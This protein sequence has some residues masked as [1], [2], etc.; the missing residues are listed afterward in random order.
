MTRLL[1]VDDD[2]AVRVTLAA[3]LELEGFEIVE[4]DS[5]ESALASVAAS[6]ADVV[7]SDVRMGG[8]NGVDLLVA[9]RRAHPD[10]PVVLT[11][12]F[13]SEELLRRAYMNGAFT[14]LPK[15]FQLDRAIKALNRAKRRPR[16]LVVDDVI[17]DAD[18]LAAAVRSTGSN[19][20]AV[21]DATLAL[22]EI[23]T[24]SYDVLVTDLSMPD[25]DGATLAAKAR[26]LDP[27]LAVIAFSAYSVP[28]IVR[29]VADVG[30]NSFIRKPFDP[31]K[32]IE[33]IAV[34]RSESPL[35]QRAV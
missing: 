32:L 10:L 31:A 13:S 30:I 28:E 33:A 4:A 22:D 35:P 25:V 18:S 11:T 16:V 6:K 20:T 15:P 3:N 24:G 7:L 8:M 27:A 19:V 1:L 9:M 14:V 5:G 12:A 17:A 23:R 21:Y 29:R 2:E 34:A 26:A